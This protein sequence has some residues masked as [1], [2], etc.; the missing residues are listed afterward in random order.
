MAIKLEVW[1]DYACYT[2]PELKTERYSYDVMTPS[3][4]VGILEAIF[5]HPGLHY[6]IDKIYV[7]NPI[8]FI[9]I[10]RNE[11]K[12]K[13]GAAKIKTA[14]KKGNL[15]TLYIDTRDKIAQRSSTVL[16]NVHYVIEAHFEIGPEANHT[17][18]EGKFQDM[19]MR[20]AR[21]GQCFHQP[22]FGTRE[23]PVKFKLWEG[24]RINTAYEGQD[25]DLGI[26]L[27]H[28]EY[29]PKRLE[30]DTIVYDA[31]PTFFRAVLKNGVLNVGES[32][33]IT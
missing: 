21:K 26:M 23:F 15:G 2:R 16:K 8:Q 25:K 11:V 14:I 29:T 17:D 18:N 28:M 22:Y 32:E 13:I 4:A 9:N 19:L 24:G 33:V 31:R 5:W 30:D 6:Q 27:H 20:R 3:A 7:L 10:K 12:E 1:G